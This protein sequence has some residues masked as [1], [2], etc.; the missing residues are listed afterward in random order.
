MAASETVDRAYEQFRRVAV[1]DPRRA[2]DL[3]LQ[4][5]SEPGGNLAQMMERAS[6]A[7]EGRVRQLVATTVRVDA[8]AKAAL[9]PWLDRGLSV[10][11][12]ESALRAIR[13][14]WAAEGPPPA[15]AVTTEL[16]KDFADTYRYVTERI[17]H[18]VRNALALPDSELL[19]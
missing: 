5:V 4:M 13:D 12:D 8:A 9:R 14:A 18:Q 1:G 2:R 7:S 16:P 10:E 3:L 15:T 19:R 17:C 6:R 11:A